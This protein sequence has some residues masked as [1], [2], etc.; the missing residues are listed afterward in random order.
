MKNYKLIF[1]Y[2]VFITIILFVVIGPIIYRVNPNAID[3]L[4][5]EKGPGIGAVLGTDSM[6]RDILARLI[7]GG[8]I[9]LTVGILATTAKVVIALVLGFISAFSRKADTIIMRMCDIFMCFPFYVLAISIAAFIG[10]SIKNLI[11]IIVFFTFSVPTRLLRTEIKTLKDKEYIQILKLNNEKTS[12]ILINHIFPNLKNT[13]LVIFTTSVA[14]AILMES[15]LSFLGMGVQDP[16]ASW[17]GM[18]SVTLNILNVQNKWWL[19]APAGILILCLI[20][21]INLIGEGLKDVRSE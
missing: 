20:F 3:M 18:L 11:V 12:K 15:S 4:R 9:S 14:Q 16:Q 1:G 2:S 6:G 13:L 5:V 7:E 21:S 10:P 17:G 19:W 8:K